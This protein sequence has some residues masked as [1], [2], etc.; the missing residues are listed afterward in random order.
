[1]P[2]SDLIANSHRLAAPHPGRPASLVAAA[3]L[4]ALSLATAV[5]ANAAES[6]EVAA[7][8]QQVQELTRRLDAIAAQ[9]ARAAQTPPPAATTPGPAPAPVAPSSSPSFMAGPV[10]VTLG[11]FVELM[12]VNRNRNESADWASNYNTSI[13]FPQSPNYNLSEFHLTERQSRFSALAQGPDDTDVAAEAYLEG[14]FGAAPSNGNNNE[15]TSFSPRVRHF[16]ADYQRKDAGWYLLFGQ[17]WSLLTQNKIGITPRQEN[18]PLTVDGQYVP[19]FNWTRTPQIRFVKTFG[20]EVAF[21][22]SLENPAALVTTATTAP[23]AFLTAN[24]YSPVFNN[25][26][27]SSAFAGL[28]TTDSA[29]D[30]IAKLAFDP[31]WGHYEVFAMDRTFRDRNP[32][33]NGAVHK[34]NSTNGVSYGAN[35]ILPLVPKVLEFSA[36]V[37]AG[38]GIGRYGSSQLPDATIKPDGSLATIKGYDVLAG[39]S[40]KPDPMW[41]FYANVGR[42]HADKTDFNVVDPATNATYGFGYGSPLFNDTGCLIESSPGACSANTSSVTSATLGGWW[43]F[44]QGAIGNMQLGLQLSHIKREVWAATI[45]GTPNTQASPST[46]IN[47]GLISFRY[48]PYQ[49]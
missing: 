2:N 30:V 35:L 29:P 8:R 6:D 22:L 34:N 20:S 7:L 9:Q 1:M 43:K 45:T 11:G 12:V 17:T 23:A 31:G 5:P 27:A 24:N 37:L 32:N 36:S 19:G 28:V 3:V 49:K 15:S 18:I 40:W 42:E 33:I 39:F 41:T 25:Q 48:Y 10:K 21:G 26:G 4:G 44:Y 16:Y 47:L 13:P 38:E 14:D 46:D